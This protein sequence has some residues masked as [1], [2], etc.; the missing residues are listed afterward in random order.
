MHF[1]IRELILWPRHDDEPR[2]VRFEPGKVNVISGASKTGKSAVI[3]IIDYCLGSDRCAIPVGEIRNA[4]SWF[5][6][7]VDTVE[8]QKLLARRE[9]GDQRSTDNMLMMEGKVVVPPRQIARHTT[10]AD[11]VKD[12]LNRLAGI[13]NLGFDPQSSSG[14]K[15]RAS[16]RDLMAFLFQP[17]NVVANPDVFFFKADTDQHREKL[18]TIFPYVL[19]AV[20]PQI[21]VAQWEIDTLNRTLRRKERELQAVRQVSQQ[22]AMEAQS[23]LDRAREYGLVPS[24]QPAPTSWQALVDLLRQIGLRSSPD[25]V[26]SSDSVG[27]G[28]SELQRL[29]IEEAA[30]ATELFEARQR[31]KE[32]ETLKASAGQYGTALE[33]QRERLALSKWLRQLAAS[34]APSPLVGPALSPSVDLEQL[35]KA[36]ETIEVEASGQP[37][38]ADTV[39]KELIRLRD[40]VRL[41]A[42]K[43]GG[44]RHRIAAL[45]ASDTT[46]ISPYSMPAIDRFLGRL[47]Q[48]IATYERVGGD[49]ELA[50]EVANLREQIAELSRGFSEAQI[51]AAV[52]R[53][54][55][56]VQTLAGA[57]IPKLDAEWPDRPIRISIPDLSIKVISPKREDWLWEIGSGANWLAYH[58]AVTAALQKFFMKEPAH[59]VP[60]MLIYYQPSQVYFPQSPSADQSAPKPDPAWRDQERGAVRKVFQAL[61]DEVDSAK[62]RLQVIVLDHADSGVWGGMPH[63]HLVEE[64]RSGRKLVPQAWITSLPRM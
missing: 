44:I 50:A 48:A 59:P 22:W 46:T 32:L 62:G 2:R 13:P 7:I 43:L 14:F 4:C 30:A 17:Q 31:L 51:N 61:S 55:Q 64:W 57:I 10:N 41:G 29:R 19:G 56:Q 34:T 15:A 6:V 28:M 24:D 42:E 3:P 18:K 27:A 11:E 53:A 9:P 45:E 60:H 37:Q 23:W 40:A 49:S 1:Q 52:N 5:G 21:L 54:L 39:D 20:T 47:E 58:T 25:S 16:F 38:I 36:L 35:C 12:M 8:G 33:L 26:P 63:L